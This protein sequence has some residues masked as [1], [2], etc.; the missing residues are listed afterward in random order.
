MG[1]PDDIAPVYTQDQFVARNG[2]H[3]PGC[4]SSKHMNYVSAGSFRDGQTTIRF[5]CERCGSYW[6]AYFNLSGFSLLY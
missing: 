6:V 2:N 3:C 5:L 1:T 4:R